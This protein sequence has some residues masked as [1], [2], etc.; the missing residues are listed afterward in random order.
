MVAS[1]TL[2]TAVT[3]HQLEVSTPSNVETIGKQTESFAMSVSLSSFD[4]NDHS[5]IKVNVRPGRFAAH[6]GMLEG[7]I[8]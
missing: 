8:T 3:K 4:S 7:L 6:V 5:S 1:L 2:R